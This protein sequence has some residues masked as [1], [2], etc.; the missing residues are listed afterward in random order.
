[1]QR[2]VKNPIHSAVPKPMETVGQ[3]YGFIL[4]RWSPKRP[5]K[6]RLAI[7]SMSDYAL[8]YQGDSKLAELD[9][10]FK[11]NAVDVDLAPAQPMTS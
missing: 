8:I 10:R 1:M 4:Y 7:I 2:R 9:R 5:T 3:S 6:G 11:Q